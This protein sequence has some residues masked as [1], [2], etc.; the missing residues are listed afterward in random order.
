MPS[1]SKLARLA[2]AVT[3]PETRALIVTVTRST[4]VRHVVRR[5]LTDRAGLIHDLR[6][7][8]QPRE[9]IGA[10]ASHPVIRELTDVG[11]VLLPMRYTP[12][13]WVA[14]WATRKAVRRFGDRSP[15][16]R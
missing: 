14:R 11:L 6:Q 4:S 7:P 2:R 1:A 5:A 10:A 3:L 12:L 15:N 16:A 8:R 13:A 9:L